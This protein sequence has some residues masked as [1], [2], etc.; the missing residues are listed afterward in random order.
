MAGW[1]E[2]LEPRTLLAAPVIEAINIIS[3][4]AG[5]TLFVP[6]RGADA[7]GD[8]LTYTVGSTNA[9]A[10]GDGPHRASLPSRYSVAGFGDMEFQLLEDLAPDTVATIRGLVESGSTTA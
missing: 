3:M 7:D 4:P 9:G 1:V 8:P 2:M 10:A 5:K 6:V